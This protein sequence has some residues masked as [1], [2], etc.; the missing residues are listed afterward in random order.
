MFDAMKKALSE[1]FGTFALVFFGTGTAVVNEV[2]GGKIGA[3][4]IALAFGLALFF[5]VWIFANVSG[6]HFNPAVTWASW[7]AGRFPGRML[8]PYFTSQVIGATAASLALRVIF[9]GSVF[10]GTTH[11]SGLPLGSFLLEI[12]LTFILML[13]ILNLPSKTQW[14]ELVAGSVVGIIVGIEAWLAGPISGA[15]MNPVRSLAPA[16][17]SGNFRDLW[18]YLAG[19]FLG[20]SLATF[21]CMRLRK[22]DCCDGLCRVHLKPDEV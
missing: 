2:M 1:A 6:A 9:P 13:G 18:I 12:F 4:G 8:L 14:K 21:A 11:P 5:I 3:A 10:L 15:S 7:L 20:A 22:K 16:L 17:V 19:P